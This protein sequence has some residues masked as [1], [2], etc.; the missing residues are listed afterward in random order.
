MIFFVRNFNVSQMFRGF[1][2]Y[3]N[4]NTFFYNSLIVFNR[5]ISC[6]VNNLSSGNICAD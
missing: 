5:N 2:I 4:D 6:V 3:L 1:I